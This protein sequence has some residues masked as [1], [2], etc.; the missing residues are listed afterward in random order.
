[1]YLFFFFFFLRISYHLLNDL[2]SSSYLNFIGIFIV[3]LVLY[4][5]Q[6][7]VSIGFPIVFF[8]SFGL[9]PPGYLAFFYCSTHRKVLT[10]HRICFFL[11]FFLWSSR[12]DY[13]CDQLFFPF[14]FV[15]IPFAHYQQSH[16]DPE[17]S[18]CFF[19]FFPPPLF[20]VS[21]FLSHF[22]SFWLNSHDFCSSFHFI[23]SLPSRVYSRKIPK[24]RLRDFSQGSSDPITF[25]FSFTRC[26][27]IFTPSARFGFCV[28][29]SF[30]FTSLFEFS[31]V[32]FRRLPS[33]PT[34]FYLPWDFSYPLRFLST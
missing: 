34:F 32:F 23:F 25:S 2:N 1:M 10:G 27:Y 22:G 26:V 17:A 20:C 7:N 31:R 5:S 30:N 3:P 4:L 24:T 9:T 33:V 12:S 14:D 15:L 6:M 13:Q 21:S 16:P 19:L 8:F 29:D 18:V 11:L 28:G